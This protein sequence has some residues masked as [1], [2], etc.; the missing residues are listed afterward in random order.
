MLLL[1]RQASLG[2]LGSVPST[3]IEYTKH[4]DKACDGAIDEKDIVY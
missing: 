3:Y 1:G 4:G 2:Y